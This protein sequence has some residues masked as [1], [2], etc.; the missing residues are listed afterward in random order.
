VITVDTGLDGCSALVTG[1]ARGI[2]AAI[3]LGLGREGC[4][5]ALVDRSAEGL[6]E[7]GRALAS[8]DAPSLEYVA[9]VRE[10]EEAR[11]VVKGVVEA[12][13]A[14][15]ILV[16]NAGITRDRISWR[17]SEEEWDDV[18]DVN[19]KGFFTYARAAAPAL[20][21]SGRGRIVAVSSINGLRGK[22][23][24]ANYAAAKAGMIGLARTLAR[25]LGADGVT[26][27]VVAPGMVRTEMTRALPA[28]RLDAARDETLLG[29][30]AEADDVA[31]VVTFL[32]SA[33][34]RHVTGAVLPV[35]GG[36]SL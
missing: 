21:A 18:L 34:A 13:G 22:P 7:T 25:E 31:Q 15:D 16:C 3:A 10:L 30:L 9:D 2:G 6:A 24:Q 27:N 1:A 4:R 8:L 28:D 32:C 5:V 36:Q 14:L 11:S 29:R 23:G 19:L 26:V 35:D 20:R 33:A 12:F 17:M